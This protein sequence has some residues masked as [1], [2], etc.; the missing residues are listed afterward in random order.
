MDYK[1][2]IVGSGMMP[3]DEIMFNPRNWRIHPLYQQDTL[4]GV[5]ETIGW[6]QEVIVNKTTGNLIDGH[7]RC[8]LAARNEEKEVPVKIVELT[9]DEEKL[10]LATL[11]PIAG[12]AT[13]DVEKRDSLISELSLLDEK[14]AELLDDIFDSE[15]LVG[16]A[17]GVSKKYTRNIT[18]PIYQITGECPKLSELY[19][20]EK[21]NELAR[22]IESAN[23]EESI[24][25]FLIAA[26]RRHVVFNYKRIAEYYAHAP[27]DIQR[28]MERSA[29]VIID[30]EKAIEYGYVKLSS[31]IL[32]QYEEDYPD[33]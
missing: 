21:A 15:E 24:K 14:T 26:S 18:A 9:E 33:G 27:E 32:E 31:I 20:E 12:M 3:L 16:G 29:L 4:K 17:D 10:V 23:I 7:L 22:E 25:R 11:D 5:L 2:R 30:F 8:Q 28:L 1:N 19:N 13:V 6:V